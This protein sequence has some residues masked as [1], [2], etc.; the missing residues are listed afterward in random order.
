M[1]RSKLFLSLTIA[2]M[3]AL[4][5]PI[6]LAYGQTAEE[7][8]G[9]LHV[10]KPVPNQY[11]VVLK[12]QEVGPA[13]QAA[14]IA[15]AAQEL[16]GQYSG[17]LGHTYQYALHGF[18]VTMPEAQA[19]A[20]SKDPRVAYVEE[21][22]I[23]ATTVSQFGVSWGLDRIDQHFG[24]NFYYNYVYTGTGVHAY[25]LDTGIMAAHSDF[26]GRATADAN[27]VHDGRDGSDCTGHGTHVAGIIGGAIY[28][29]AKNVRLHGVRVLGCQGTGWNSDVIAGVDWV[30]AN[31]ILPAVA[32]MSLEVPG[33]PA[34]DGAVRNSIA[35][36]IT[37]V[38][39]A[40]NGSTDAMYVSPARVTQAITVG[41]SD[42]GTRFTDLKASFSN[43]G[44]YLDIF[45]PGAGIDSDWND[46]GSNRLWGTSQASPHVAGAAALYLQNNP[47]ASPAT[48]SHAITAAA[49]KNLIVDPGPGSPNA[50]LYVAFPTATV[51]IAG[52]EQHAC[53]ID[54]SAVNCGIIFD[55]GTVTVTVNGRSY[56]V[57]YGKLSLAK[58]IALALA[59]SINS[60]PDVFATAS[61]T[62]INLVSR[63]GCYTL[64][65]D[66][67]TSLPD[68][69]NPS[70]TATASGP[71]CP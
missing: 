7:P 57:A 13:L 69:F 59:A 16:T 35:H 67:N 38:V 29:V 18:S 66:S 36:G 53:S 14:E 48:V 71:S 63:I 58:N 23:A 11:I 54:T 37:Y 2:M 19:L 50:L 20:L 28:G 42:M 49:T 31:A 4:A 26:G 64:S 15:A 60:D 25:V 5:T 33:D 9:L 55:A 40:G 43:F 3:V 51:T 44:P 17:N 70:F 6:C 41:A 10:Q 8:T 46:G 62:V 61:G 1:Q 22:S 32:N 47:N 45:A 30:T 12:E 27:F 21:D 68:Y 34:L 24:V 52:Q 65:A 56:S 39:S